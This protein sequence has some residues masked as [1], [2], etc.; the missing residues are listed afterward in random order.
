[1]DAVLLW[2][3]RTHKVALARSV[4]IKQLYILTPQPRMSR[5]GLPEFAEQLGE[6]VGVL[7]VVPTH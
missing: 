1:M 6:A 3:E 2:Q 4:V 5:I 7:K